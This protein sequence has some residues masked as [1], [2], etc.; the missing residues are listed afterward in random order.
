MT[1]EKRNGSTV[2]FDIQKIINAVLKAVADVDKTVSD[3]SVQIATNIAKDIYEKVKKEKKKVFTVEEIQ[4]MVI[5]GLNNSTRPDVGQ[6]YA[7][8]R[9]KHAEK[10]KKEDVYEKMIDEKLA[11][12]VEKE[13]ELEKR[14]GKRVPF[15]K[16]KISRAILKAAADVDKNITDE[17]LQLA[18]KIATAIESEAYASDSVFSVEE[19]QDKVIERLKNSERPDIGGAYAAYRQMRAKQRA[20]EEKRDKLVRD[21]L[22]AKDVQNANANVD[23]NSFSGRMAEA[24]DVITKD[25]ALRSMSEIARRNHEENMIYQHD[26]NSYV[27]GM[28]N[29][30]SLPLDDC[31]AS[32]VWVGDTFLRPARSVN[33]A[34]NLVAVISQLQS[35]CQFGK[36]RCRTKT[37]WTYK[38]RVS[39]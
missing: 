36:K 27:V 2:S 9:K 31:L 30:L 7:D 20:E 5:D 23:E 3:E 39:A 16:E 17:S 34:M 10:R 33:T 24:R 35:Q 21:K 15:N 8:F 4:D 29:C 18:R 13:I 32:G 6:A 12:P 28:H 37:L 38:Y 11:G 19:V 1:I 22:G 26:L 14:N 25:M